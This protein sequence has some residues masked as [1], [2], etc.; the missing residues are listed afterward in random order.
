MDWVVGC[1][2]G[3]KYASL[4]SSGVECY[5][6]VFEHSFRSKYGQGGQW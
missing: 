1:W 4:G 6:G 2:L 5:V 3:V